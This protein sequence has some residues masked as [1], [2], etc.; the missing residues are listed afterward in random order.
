MG[1]GTELFGTFGRVQLAQAP[2]GVV[3][4]G[5]HQLQVAIFHDLTQVAEYLVVNMHVS[6]LFTP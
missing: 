2:F 6:H 3:K 1:C 4:K 5:L